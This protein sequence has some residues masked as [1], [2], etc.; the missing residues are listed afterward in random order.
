VTE[1]L[2]IWNWISRKNLTPRVNITA[3]QEHQPERSLRTIKERFRALYSQCPF[4]MWPKIMIIR[5]ASE[6]VKWLNSFPPA[7]GLSTVGSPRAIILGRPIEFDAPCVVRFGSFVQ[8]HTRIDPT[9]TPAERTS[10]A[11]FLRTLDNIQ[12]GYELLNS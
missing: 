12:G 6:V 7:G 2:R 1:S 9:N 4:K 8:A 5:G 3:A 11:I 10:D